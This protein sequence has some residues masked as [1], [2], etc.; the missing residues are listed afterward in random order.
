MIEN[1]LVAVDD[2]SAA[3]AG[4]RLAVELAHAVNATVHAIAVVP[5]ADT[6]PDADRSARLEQNASA[7]LAHVARTAGNANVA[8]QTTLRRG[9][10]APCILDRARE[11]G[12]DLMVVGRSGRPGPGQPFIGSQTRRILEFAESPVIVVPE[13]ERPPGLART[14]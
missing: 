6:G 5:E 3:L 4:A 12:A 9:D 13:A 2:T 14:G 8:V 11:V 1:I 10:P 7:V